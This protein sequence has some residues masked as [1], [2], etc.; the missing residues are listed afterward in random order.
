MTMTETNYFCAPSSPSLES[1]I[2]PKS[3]QDP[4][5]DPDPNLDSDS[6]PDPNLNSDPD[7]DPFRRP[8]SSRFSEFVAPFFRRFSLYSLADLRG[9][10]ATNQP[11]ICPRDE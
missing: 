8:N 4:D 9:H 3:N 2:N 11:T 7:S 1:D 6:D 10:L 5:F